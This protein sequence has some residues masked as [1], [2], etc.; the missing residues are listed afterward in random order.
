MTFFNQLVFD[1][2]QLLQFISRRGKFITLNRAEILFHGDHVKIK[3]SSSPSRGMADRGSLV[4]VISCRGL[5]CRFGSF[6]LWRRSSVVPYPR[7]PLCNG[8]ISS[9]VSAW[10]LIWRTTQR[11]PSA[12][13]ITAAYRPEGP[14]LIRRTC[15]AYH[16]CSVR[17]YRRRSDT[18]VA[19]A[20]ECFLRWAPAIGSYPGHSYSLSQ[21]SSRSNNSPATL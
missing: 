14:V 18:S 8:S 20:T 17:A 11:I 7:S 19:R 9:R 2:P 3:I 15:T 5:V 10:I 4:L 21:I 12:G 6:Q 13:T 16:V 1:T